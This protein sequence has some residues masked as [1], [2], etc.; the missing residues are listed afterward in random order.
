M[1]D[2]TDTIKR[3]TDS[4]VEN[5]YK[6]FYQ[7][8][9]AIEAFFKR[10]SPIAETH[11][12]EMQKEINDVVFD[13]FKEIMGEE[14]WNR[15]KKASE[16][17]TEEKDKIDGDKPEEEVLLTVEE[18]KRLS[19]K[20][21][22][23]SKSR[24][25]NYNI[26]AKGAFIMLNNYF[27]FIFSDLLT[28]HFTK[29]STAMDSKK[30][31]IALVEF[32]KYTTVE[33][34]YRDLIYKEVETLLLNMNFEELKAYFTE[35]L[36]I[37]LE[38]TH[39]DW[40]LI[41]E[42]RERRHIIVHNNSI[43]NNKYLT[44]SGNPFNLKLNSEV[45]IDNDYFTKAL[46]ELKLAGSLLIF[47]C[48]GNWDKSTTTK[49]V[50]ELMVLSFDGLKDADY[51][52][53]KAI[54]DYTERYVTPKND[55]EHD[56]LF[57][58]KF[59]NCIALKKLSLHKELERKLNAIKVGALAPI[60]KIAHLILKGKL[61]ESLQLFSKAKV[62]DELTLDKYYLWPLFDEIRNNKELHLIALKELN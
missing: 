4:S 28:Y 25:K 15:L 13:A 44:R 12:K 33:E 10:L 16:K 8:I 21:A 19:V 52:F 34:A 59:N 7:N 61:E 58:I 29:N 6:S 14:R 42:I 26:L 54:C 40:N 57:R 23:T 36:N 17:Q 22:R 2:Y 24:P 37:D 48:W 27:E 3:Q 39:I 55:E 35:K 50:S 45:L 5:I 49:A 9:H 43:V 53:S 18:V 32:K 60:F 31:S 30:V 51:I 47:N 46:R 41:N 56:L 62:A 11:D 20:L 1:S 38:E